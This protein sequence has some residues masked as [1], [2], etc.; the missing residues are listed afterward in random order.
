M[1]QKEKLLVIL[2]PTSSGKSDLAVDLALD[3]NGEVVS[4]DSRQVYTG[5]DIGSGKIMTEEMRGVPHYLLDV[6][7]P[8]DTY[9]VADYKTAATEA[10][11]N[12]HAK[13]KLPILCGGT[14]FYI[15][16]VVDNLDLPE[17]PPDEELRKELE[18]K[19]PE[20]L[21]NLLEEQDPDRAESI[22]PHNPRR[23]IRALEIVEAL[24]KVPSLEKES[25]YDVL[26]LG[27]ETPDDVL[28]ERIN[29]RVDRR[30][31]DGMIEE[32]ERLY[33]EG[34]SWERMDELGLEYRYISY[35]LK[36]DLSKEEMIEILKTKIWQYAKRQKTW[37]KKDERIVWVRVE[38]RKLIF[39]IVSNWIDNS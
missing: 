38:E 3:F 13:G 24:G 30:L 10:I 29:N 34:L 39:D 19:T 23:L 12:I 6:A 4:A 7:N 37:F 26:L 5:L 25:P 31:E 16:A 22:D 2:G 11:D 36:G 28:R 8:R 1:N 20:E 9:S 14:G 15:Q 33:Q 18:Q 27:I 21:F 35:F 17:V 32:V